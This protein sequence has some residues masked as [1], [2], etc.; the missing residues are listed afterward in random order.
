M[1]KV[2]EVITENEGL[3][4]RHKSLVLHSMFDSFEVED[5]EDEEEDVSS[6]GKVN[7]EQI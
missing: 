3:H 5:D 7:L 4:E 6:E 2:K 1:G